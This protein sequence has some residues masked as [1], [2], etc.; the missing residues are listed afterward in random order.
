M[1]LCKKLIDKL[2]EHDFSI[3]NEGDGTY[4]FGKYSPAGQDFGFL[5]DAGESLDDLFAEAVDYERG[6]DPS[7]EASSWLGD[8]GHG[9]NGAPY[10]MKDLYDDM[11]ACK[12]IIK[13]FIQILLDVMEDERLAKKKRLDRERTHK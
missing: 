1:K 6:F 2:E 8:D 7:Y 11:V 9:K 4:Y 13:E 3:S 10:D 5:L 12:G